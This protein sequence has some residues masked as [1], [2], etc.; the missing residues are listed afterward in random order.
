MILRANRQ[1]EWS[2]PSLR[3]VRTVLT[4]CAEA[5]RINIQTAPRNG[6]I[7]ES[8]ITDYEWFDL[9]E[10]VTDTDLLSNG[11]ADESERPCFSLQKTVFYTTKGHLS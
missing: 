4:D 6:L 1:D 2:G 10:T 7:A 11:F 3:I 9:S 5:T 8:C